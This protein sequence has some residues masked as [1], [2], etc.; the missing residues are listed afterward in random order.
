MERTVA[1]GYYLY[2]VYE[3]LLLYNLGLMLNSLM[4]RSIASNPSKEVERTVERT[5]RL[6][7]APLR[8]VFDEESL[9]TSWHSRGSCILV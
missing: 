9:V 3:R 7:T 8:K 6:W 2:L 5:R 1:K 4:C